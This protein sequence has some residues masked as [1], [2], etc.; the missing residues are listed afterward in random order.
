MRFDTVASAVLVGA[1]VA[2]VADPRTVTTYVDA[3]GNRIMILG[4]GIS[5][6]SNRNAAQV[7]RIHSQ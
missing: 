4:I 6:Q 1:V 7:N 3:D 2:A 5:S